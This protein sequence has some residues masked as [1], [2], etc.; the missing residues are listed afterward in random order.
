MAYST[1]QPVLLDNFLAI[2]SV[3][4]IKGEPSAVHIF[5]YASSVFLGLRGSMK[6]RKIN[7]C[8]NFG[9]S[10]TLSSDKKTFK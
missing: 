8:K 9:R 7:C 3:E 5:S 10:T 6:R 4:I 2:L 1:F